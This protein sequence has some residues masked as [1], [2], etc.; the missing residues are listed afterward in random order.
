MAIFENGKKLENE[1]LKEVNG[2]YIYNV[3]GDWYEIIDDKT[4][5]VIERGLPN[6]D[7]AKARAK[8][9]GQSDMGLNWWQLDSL[10][11]TGHI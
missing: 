10:R 4:G 6:R 7:Q 8:E 3:A 9:L 5:D 1:E 2:G 11:K